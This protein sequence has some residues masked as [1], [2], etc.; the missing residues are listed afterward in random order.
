MPNA[1]A[2]RLVLAPYSEVSVIETA[3]AAL[4]EVGGKV[5]C[6]FAFCSA[7]Y[8]ENLSDFM[9]LLQL[10]ARA[11][12]V[13]GCSASGLIGTGLEHEKARGF[14][15]LLLHLPETQI[16]QVALPASA[17]AAA[18]ALPPEAMREADAWIVLGNPLAEGIEP[19]IEAWN[20]T[21]PGV[22]CIGGLASSGAGESDLFAWSDRTEVEGGVAL[23]FKGGVRVDALVSQGCRPIGEPWSITGAER[24]YIITLGS[25]PAFEVLQETFQSLPDSEKDQ[26]QGNIFVGLATSEYVDEFKTGDF[27][28]RN[29][30]GGDPKHGVIAVGA[31]PRVGQTLQFQLRD[32]NSAD[33]EL[34]HLTQQR[35]KSGRAPFAS[36]LFACNGRGRHLFGVPNHDA[37]VLV[38]MLGQ[39]PSAGFFCNGEIGPVGSRNFIHGYTASAALF[40]EA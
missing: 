19:W 13:A 25:R 27:L 24:N 12:I 22:A 38:E 33:A 34:R 32:A 4:R 7:D 18:E 6:A 3:T 5:S 15:I 8:R 16:A 39:H 2:S 36:L 31:L 17:D 11:P 28:I 40:S 10:H 21:L 26:A 20:R 9:E 23:G 1:A 29:L 30:L 14:S 37:A 35:R